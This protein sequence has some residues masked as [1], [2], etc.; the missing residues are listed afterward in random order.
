MFWV[1]G[2]REEDGILGE[3]AIRAGGTLALGQGAIVVHMYVLMCLFSGGLSLHW[4][5]CN[6]RCSHYHGIYPHAVWMAVITAADGPVRQNV[7]HHQRDCR[8]N[9]TTGNSFIPPS[10]PIRENR[11]PG[12]RVG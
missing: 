4:P 12:L 9:V 10:L 7:S 8:G 11:L 2:D 6:P 5:H 1:R 3:Y